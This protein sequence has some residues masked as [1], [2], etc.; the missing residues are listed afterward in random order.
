MPHIYVFLNGFLM[1]LAVVCP[2]YGEHILG[3]ALMKNSMR[4]KHAEIFVRVFCRN[5]KQIAKKV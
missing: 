4:E 1:Q 5:T 3:E 2:G